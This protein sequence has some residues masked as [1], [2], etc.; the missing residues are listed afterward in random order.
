MFGAA[1]FR[2]MKATAYL[3]NVARGAIVHESAL[4][5]ALEAGTAGPWDLRIATATEGGTYKAIGDD[6]SI[7]NGAGYVLRMLADKGKDDE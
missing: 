3:I 6:F 2:A 4:I 5:A 1:Q 7:A